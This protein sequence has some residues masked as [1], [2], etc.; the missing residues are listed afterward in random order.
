M[1][2]KI[3]S[4]NSRKLHTY[5]YYDSLSSISRFVA[6]APPNAALVQLGGFTNPSKQGRESRLKFINVIPKARPQLAR[7]TA[8]NKLSVFIWSRFICFMGLLALMIATFAEVQSVPLPNAASTCHR[9]TN[10]D[11]TPSWT[12]SCTNEIYAACSMPCCWLESLIVWN[13][14]WL[15]GI[16]KSPCWGH[17]SF[18][19]L[20]LFFPAGSKTTSRTDDILSLMIIC[21]KECV[22]W[23]A[24]CCESLQKDWIAGHHPPWSAHLK[25]AICIFA[26]LPSHT[27]WLK[28]STGVEVCACGGHNLVYFHV[29]TLPQPIDLL[30]H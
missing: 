17:C 18:S 2:W 24:K 11:V 12:W 19:I 15:F 25:A 22:D 16:P 21:G 30:G 26:L 28:F 10:L 29:P 14:A 6:L 13:F 4:K 1:D 3:E 23:G 8:I 7:N 27:M 9:V 5:T 20:F